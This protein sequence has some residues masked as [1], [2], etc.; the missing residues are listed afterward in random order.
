[1]TLEQLKIF[2]AVAERQHLTQAAAALFL[3]PSAVS[4]AIR[5]LEERYDLALFNRVGRRIELSDAGRIFLLEARRTLASIRTLENTLAELGGLGRGSLTL[6]ASQTVSSY[7]LPPLLVRFRQAHPSIELHMEVGNTEQVSQAV[8]SGSADLGF[9]EG[10]IGASALAVEAVAQDRMVVVVAPE[11]PWADG[12]K[13][14]VAD[15]LGARWIL[16]EAGSGTR[17][18]FAAALGALGVEAEA[19]DVALELPSN[20]AVRSAV[21]AGPFATAMSALVV[22]AP[23]RAGLLAQANIAL[24]AREFSM[25]R[26]PARHRSRAAAAFEALARAGAPA[27]AGA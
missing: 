3:T 8:L 9:V 23:L 1:M 5:N 18:A 12:R 22:V 10:A 25:L 11:H 4:A 16:R 24:P 26:H 19:L 15:L 2:V 6:H 21:T 20:E 13:L 14:E 7:W 17:S 27:S